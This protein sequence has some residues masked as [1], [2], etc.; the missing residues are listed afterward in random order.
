V[1]QRLI[2]LFVSVRRDKRHTRIGEQKSHKRDD[3]RGGDAAKKAAATRRE[4]KE[5]EARRET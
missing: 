5:E 1:A 3:L 2:A 4:H